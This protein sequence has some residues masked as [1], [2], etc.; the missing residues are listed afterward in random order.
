MGVSMIENPMPPLLP[1]KEFI[2]KKLRIN[3]F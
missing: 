2:S 1:F 3:K